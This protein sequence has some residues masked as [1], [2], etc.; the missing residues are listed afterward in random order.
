MRFI[1]Y[2]FN[3]IRA[4]AQVLS[5]CWRGAPLWCKIRYCCA[6]FGQISNYEYVFIL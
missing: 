6:V 4:L 3:E 2:T 1:C 5:Q